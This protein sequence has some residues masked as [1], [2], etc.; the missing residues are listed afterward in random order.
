MLSKVSPESDILVID[1]NSM[2]GTIDIVKRYM[3]RSSSIKMIVR[4]SERGLGTALLRGYKEA[5]NRGYEVIVQ[6]DADLQHPPEKVPELIKTIREGYDVAVASR[7][8]IGGGILGWPYYRRLISKVANNY[9]KYLLGLKIRDVT[10]G[11]RAFSRKAI[12]YIL[13]KNLR[14]KGYIV[15]VET[16]YML[17]KAGFKIKECPFIFK[18]RYAG[19]SKLKLKIILE[20]F[21][22]VP[23]IRIRRY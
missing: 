22:K 7:Y 3:T 18:N 2:D 6:M 5:Y 23:Y 21:I 12:E 8:V 1:D 17:E 19:E 15:Q 9:A 11:F 20:Y 16:L 10:T 14:S 4:E 13:S